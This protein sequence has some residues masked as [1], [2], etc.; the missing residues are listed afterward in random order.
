MT[1]IDRK[2]APGAG[3]AGWLAIALACAAIATGVGAASPMAPAQSLQEQ[4][5]QTESKLSHARHHEGV[6][7]T[8]ISHESKQISTLELQVADL[9]NKIAAAAAELA[10]KQAELDQAK[11]QLEILRERLRLSIKTLE[12]RLVA[13]YE[14]SPP[15]VV[16]V[17]LQSHGFDDLLERTEY[18][19]R[20]DEQDN[21]IVARV[22]DLR[23]QMQVTVNT[24]TAARD[25]IAQRKAELDR[26]HAKL[27]SRK[28]ELAAARRRHRATLSEVRA[29]RE[30]LEGDL[31]RISAR[32]QEQL[33]QLDVGA[34]PAGPI[35]AGSGDMIW[36]VNGPITSGFGMRWGRMH[37][38]IDIS[39]PTG[40]PIRAAKSGSIVLASAYGGYGNYTCISHGGGQSTC[41]GHQS[42]FALTSGSVS[43]G[44]VIGYV[45]STG[46]ST[47]PHLHFEVRINGEAVDPL[48]Y[49]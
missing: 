23:N 40:T 32:I 25:A 26:A 35:R 41:Y 30:H 7:T 45:G 37:E 43:Q 4:L 21:E 17:L 13:I 15:D 48:G 12:R 16:T 33:A 18:L 1:V 5:E 9:R 10:Q 29:H 42:G 24:V 27:D 11:A 46:N 36:P 8:E 47:G 19:Q 6:L 39:A 22:R 34:L 3:R 28:D 2:A 31:S 44:T 14:S 20:L 38:G 49:L